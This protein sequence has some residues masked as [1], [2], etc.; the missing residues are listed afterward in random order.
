[1]TLLAADPKKFHPL[2]SAQ[3]ISAE[4][5]PLPALSG[6]KLFVKTNEGEGSEVVCVDIGSR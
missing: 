1:L 3:F 5:R 2:G 4:T 6:G